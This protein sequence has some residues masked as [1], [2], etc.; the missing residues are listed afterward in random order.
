MCG[1][2]CMKEEVKSADRLP[3]NQS[4]AWLILQVMRKLS[5]SQFL[6]NMLK[7]PQNKEIL[8]DRAIA[9]MQVPPSSLALSRCLHWR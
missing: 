3:V 7:G 6:G 2:D 9:W 8:G 5:K 4:K 1:D